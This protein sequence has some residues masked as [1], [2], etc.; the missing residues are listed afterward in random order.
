VLIDLCISGGFI[1]VLAAKASNNE[2]IKTSEGGRKSHYI[3]PD[4]NQWRART[5]L[6][7]YS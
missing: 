6:L 5:M 1:K 3:N 4:P 7:P 2:V